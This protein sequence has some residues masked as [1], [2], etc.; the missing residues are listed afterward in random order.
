[1]PKKKTAETTA[2]KKEN[3]KHFLFVDQANRMMGI[4]PSAVLARIDRGSKRKWPSLTIELNPDSKEVQELLD[5]LF[6]QTLYMSS[7]FSLYS[8]VVCALGLSYTINNESREQNKR[9]KR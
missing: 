1:M 5:E 4:T 2:E 8:P 3:E 9:M 7:P 6:P